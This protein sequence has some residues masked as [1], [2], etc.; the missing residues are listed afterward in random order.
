M[1]RQVMHDLAAARGM[2]HVNRILQPEMIGDRF[3]VVRVMVHVV[4]AAGLGGAAMSAPIGGDHA[5]TFAKEKEHLRIPII[6]RERPAVTEDDG[7]STAPVFIIDVDVL[8]VFLTGSDVRHKK[9]PVEWLV[10]TR[11]DVPPVA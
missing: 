4:A 8:S 2:P 1:T 7:L 11:C 5:V 10:S 3:Q 9:T 6:R